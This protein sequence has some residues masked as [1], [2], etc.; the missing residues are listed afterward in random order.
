M[1]RY[2][3]NIIRMK[4][5]GLLLFSMLFTIISCTK[6]QEKLGGN[7]SPVQVSA[8]SLAPAIL[9]QGVYNSM[10]FT[11]TSYLQVFALSDLTTDEAIAPTRGSNWDDNG[12]WRVFHQQKYD[13][14]NP[15][16]HDCF[17]SLSGV[18]FAATDMLQYKPTRQQQAEARF[19]RAW[20]MY[21]MLDMFDQFPYREP[22][23]PV[24]RA[25]NVHK[26]ID[27]LSYIINEINAVEP[28]LP[29][30]PASKANIFAA[31]VLLMKCYL[32][33][34]VYT[35]RTNPVFDPTDM[36]KV[37]SLADS[38]I[39]S[40]NFHFSK[41]YFDNFSPDNGLTSRENIFTQKGSGDGSYAL[42]LA[43]LAV[44]YYKV[45]PSIFGGE[46]GFTTLQDFYNKFEPNDKRR[47][48]AYAYPNSPPNPGNRV[49][50]GFLIGQQYDLYT[51]DTLIDPMQGNLHVIYTPEVQNVEPGPNILMTGIRPVKY[52]PDYTN[53]YER[54]GPVQNDFV[55]LRFPDVLL[56]KAEAIFRGGTGIVAGVYGNTALSLVNSVRTNPS[57]GASPMSSVTLDSI[58]DERGREFWWENWRR[59]DM[60][61]FGKFLLPFQEKKYL[62]DQ[63][64][65]LFPIPFEQIA[66]NSNLKQNP[67]Y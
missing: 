3:K 2:I 11:F 65:L 61:R 27:A 12:Q 35:N 32:N 24:T 44:L 60:I 46:N 9:L 42:A 67:G 64:Y 28:D 47:E 18:V 21:W 36:N 58:Y 41:N 45:Q 20:A 56:M 40:N 30:G 6:L 63:K 57:R 13:P 38:V 43:W 8:D 14:N 15:V 4:Y 16:I 62:S 52:A 5:I 37:I 25:A 51:N 1:I 31:K 19:L 49:N 59:Q 17:N 50:V 53:F 66:I 54:N 33:K 55:Y 39:N 10:E 48:A 23:E 34:A 22:G 7:L 29:D 26:G